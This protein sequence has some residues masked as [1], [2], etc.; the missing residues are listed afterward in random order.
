MSKQ[1]CDI[2][3]NEIETGEPVFSV[4]EHN[5]LCT[6]C[7]DK[8]E[9]CSS[10][11]DR[12]AQDEFEELSG[13]K[14]CSACFDNIEVCYSCDNTV[15]TRRERY[16]IHNDDFIAVPVRRNVALMNV[17]LAQKLFL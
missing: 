7:Y 12:N 2:C 13:E 16:F 4:S 8:L 5:A 3:T 10:C 15:N 14:Y 11:G 9:K 6:E 17:K 1:T